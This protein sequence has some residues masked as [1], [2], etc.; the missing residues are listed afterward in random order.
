MTEA[1]IKSDDRGIR[2][3]REE[4]GCGRLRRHRAARCQRLSA[5]AVHPP[6]LEPAHRCATAARSR[7][8][9]ASCSKSPKAPIAAIGKR[10]GRHPPVALRRVQRHAALSG[11]GRRLHLSGP[12]AQCARAGLHPSGRSFAR[13]ARRW[14]RMRSRRCSATT[15]KR[16]LI[17][18][19]G[20]DA[21]RAESDL[22]AGKCDLVAVG[23]PFLANP[24]LVERWRAGAAAQRARHGH[25]LHAGAEGLHRLP[26]ARPR[27]RLIRPSTA[28]CRSAARGCACRSPRRSRC[29][30]P[31]SPA[32]AAARP[33]R[34]A[35][36]RRGEEVH[37]D[38]GR[39]RHPQRR[40][41][42]EI[43]LHHAAVLDGDLLVQ[44][45]A[46]AVEDR[47]LRHVV[48]RG[49]VD[50]LAADV[51]DRPDIVDLDLPVGRRPP[52][53]PPRR[54]SRDGCN[55]RQRPCR[56]AP[57][58]CAGPSRRPRAP[59]PA[60]ARARPVLKPS[61]RPGSNSSLPSRSIWNCQ[62]VLARGMRHLVDEGLEHEGEPVVA[63][64]AQR[65]GRDAGRH[66][67]GAIGQVRHA[68]GRE[69]VGVEIGR[70]TGTRPFSPKLTKCCCQA[71]SLPSASRPPLKK[72]QPAGR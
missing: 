45:L 18:S 44:R 4:R 5:R 24:D 69:R 29:T 32:A 59:S 64:R 50:D 66:E 11:D 38:G 65:A 36:G 62:R 35:G 41:A 10:Q 8:A 46:E 15:F 23:K 2:P 52:P 43:R 28:T 37:L 42:V 25:V 60:R 26:G 48:R 56:C 71:T 54:N 14:C 57:A 49:R 21:A 39:L 61:P 53:R 1:D 20:Y 47:A 12:E 72:C 19:G 70:A 13:W 31:A 30:A 58:A 34:S 51:A 7:T 67:R 16:T 3:G 33:G 68:A 17:L 27:A 22:K 63:G 55:R 40:E 6:E 9:R